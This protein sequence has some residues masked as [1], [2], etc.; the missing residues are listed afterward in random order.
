MKIKKFCE[1]NR[2]G[3]TNV[4]I[5]R[6]TIV[7]TSPS[8]SFKRCELTQDAM[9]ISLL[10]SISSGQHVPIKAYLTD[11]F[12]LKRFMSKSGQALIKQD[13]LVSD[14][15]STLKVTFWENFVDQA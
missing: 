15:T 6:H 10:G 13:G 2:Y 3:T 11:L 1:N 8:L 7:E 4:I 12:G 9:T 5:E 14:P